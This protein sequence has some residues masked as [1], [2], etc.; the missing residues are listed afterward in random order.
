MEGLRKKVTIVGAG[1]NGL[2]MAAHLA[3]E[4]YLV[5]IWNRSE[6]TIEKIIRTKTIKSKGYINGEF[7]IELATTHLKEAM[8]GSEFIF[9]TQPAHTH[10]QLA[11]IM[12][13]YITD[14]M[15][16][17]LNPGRTFGIFDFRK[18]LLANGVKKL[19]AL[20]ETQTII[21]TCRKLAEDEVILLEMK[22]NV[23]LSTFTP[24][25]NQNFINA[26][27]SCIAERYKP[28]KS[29]VET[30]LGNVGMIL[31]SAPVLL[32]TGWIE[33]KE[34]QF[35]YYYSG[36]TPSIAGLLEKLD[37]ERVGVAAKLGINTQSIVEWFGS[38]YNVYHEK[39]YDCIQGVESYKTI[40][41]PTSL[42]HR[43]IFEDIKTGLVPLE[44]M[45]KYLGF[46]MK[47]TSLIIDLATELLNYN[48]RK[49]GRNLEGDINELIDLLKV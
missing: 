30:S 42:D 40:D 17:V 31:H 10:N 27:P 33:N 19:P 37:K 12:A 39:L 41:A 15:I 5:K 7:K 47:I 20:A 45:G 16:L 18:E 13:P 49:E 8:E 32:N 3:S 46:E 35:L 38:C 29:M 21:Y 26:L 2:T 48:F 6:K 23:L 28:A 9:I 24:S 4:G 11:S 36:I 34:T 44:A 43:Y 14:K 22:N 1:N 25:E